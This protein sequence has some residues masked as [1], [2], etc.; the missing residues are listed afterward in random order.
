MCSSIRYLQRSVDVSFFRNDWPILM[1]DGFTRS[2][3]ATGP[4]FNPWVIPS[5]ASEMYHSVPAP[6]EDPDFQPEYASLGD[7]NAWAPLL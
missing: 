1:P 5:D 7:D 2:L 3:S 6:P 4:P